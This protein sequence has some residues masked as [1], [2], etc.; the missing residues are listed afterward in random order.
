M[1]AS[2]RIKQGKY[3]VVDVTYN[4]KG[5]STIKEISS[6]LIIPESVKNKQ[7]IPCNRDFVVGTQY[8]YLFK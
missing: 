7:G 1:A 6:W 4:K 8:E 2:I 3:Q 5:I